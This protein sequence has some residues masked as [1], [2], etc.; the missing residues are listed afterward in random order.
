MAKD[1]FTPI[2]IGNAKINF[3]N[4][5]ELFATSAATHDAHFH[6]MFEIHIILD[7]ES[8]MNVNGNSYTL[9]K[10]KLIIIPPHLSHN[11]EFNS[12]N[13]RCCVL[14]FHIEPLNESTKNRYEYKYFSEL[15]STED[16]KLLKLRQY[17]LSIISSILKNSNIFSIYAVNKINVKISDLFLEIAH[18]LSSSINNQ[19]ELSISSNEQSTRKYKIERFIQQCILKNEKPT[20]KELS[21]YLFI[22]QRHL[23]RFINQSYNLTF[24]QLCFKHQMTMAQKMIKSS[25]AT[26]SDIALSLGY[27][28]YKG[29]AMAYK[30]Y[31]GFPPSKQERSINT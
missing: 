20:L 4:L 19:T 30:K 21:E 14:S 18:R 9:S 6:E 27:D 28:S 31:Y 24:K 11:T 16:V 15:F 25:S 10:N 8:K 5:Y 3:L 12:D 2:T 22:S 13:Y 23:E 17:D 1:S 26:L 7:G 29:F